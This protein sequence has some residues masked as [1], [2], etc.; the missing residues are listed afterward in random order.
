ML[1]NPEILKTVCTA[2]ET[3]AYRSFCTHGILKNCSASLAVLH[4]KFEPQSSI[5]ADF[6]SAKHI[7]SSHEI[8]PWSPV[9]LIPL[10]NLRVLLRQILGQN[11]EL[12][13][14]SLILCHLV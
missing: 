13:P 3:F 9:V 8:T 2:S 7:C 12:P 14:Y 10:K 6:L 11:M 5:S 4:L 1:I